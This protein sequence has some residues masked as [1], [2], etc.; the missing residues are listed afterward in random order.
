METRRFERLGREVSRLGLAATGLYKRPDVDPAQ[1][2]R[3]IGAAIDRGV[4]VIGTAPHLGDSE[5]LCGQTLRQLHA[6]ERVALVTHVP[7]ASAEAAEKEL[8]A[9]EEGVAFND[10][11]PKIWSPAYLENCLEKSLKATTLEVL[12]VALL[13]GW[14]DSWLLSTAWP[15]IQGAM[16]H[17]QKKGK[18]LRWGL[19]L[20]AAALAHTLKI[21]DEPLIAMVAAPYNLWSVA[22]EKLAAAAVERQ[23]AFLAQQVL[24]QG[25]LS[26]EV[27]ATAVF[28]PGDVRRELFASEPGRIELSRRVAELAAFTKSIPPAAQSSDAAR[29]ALETARRDLLEGGDGRARECET[30]AE[31]AVRFAISA[32]PVTCAMV[33]MSSVAHVHANADAVERG[34]LPEHALAPVREWVARYAPPPPL[35]REEEE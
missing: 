9:D 27:V 12:P 35:R 21:L 19:S 33:G 30:L 20:P 28:P 29:E 22:A 23:V 1:A 8:L 6:W 34:P 3:A 11:L 2:A 26:G 18:V 15:E 14:H 17:M 31:L 25:G 24:G 4:N 13:E 16:A 10:P 32:P 5:R 7:P